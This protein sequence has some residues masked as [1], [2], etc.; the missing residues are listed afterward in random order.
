MD[1][2]HVS[3]FWQKI[4]NKPVLV[5]HFIMLFEEPMF[6]RMQISLIENQK[7]SNYYQTLITADIT[8]VFTKLRTYMKPS[9]N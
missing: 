4:R 3:A 8:D 7:E 1:L 9:A 5:E 6:A 2:C